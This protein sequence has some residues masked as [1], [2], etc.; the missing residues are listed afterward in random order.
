MSSAQLIQSQTAAPGQTVSVWKEVAES[1]YGLGWVYRKVWQSMPTGST[2]AWLSWAHHEHFVLTLLAHGEVRHAVQVAGLQVHSERVEVVT[3]DAGPDF[4]RDWLQQINTP[5]LLLRQADALKLAR[6]FL[7]ALQSIHALGVVHGDV[8]ADNVCIHPLPSRTGGPVCLDLG[9]LRLIDFAY[10]VYRERP[11]KFVLPTDPDRL[12]Y[13]P[14]FYRDAIRQAQVQNDPALIQRRACAQVDLFSLCCLLREVVP[15]NSGADGVVWQRFLQ[16]CTE[17][18]TR[19]VSD[20]ALEAPTVRLLALTETLLTQLHEPR[21]QWEQAV[22]TLLAWSPQASAT[23]LLEAQ[24]TPLLTPL[25][26]DPSHPLGTLTMSPDEA[27]RGQSDSMVLMAESPSGWHGRLTPVLSLLVLAAVFA[28]I[29]MRFQQTGE[30]LSD[31][32]FGLGLL[33]MVLG[34]LLVVTSAWNVWTSSRRAWRWARPLALG[35]CVIASYFLIVLSP[36]GVSGITLGLL[37]F[38][39][40]VL[41]L[42]W[43][44]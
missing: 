40:A 8:K 32:G 34:P 39:L 9:S 4:R 30:V 37:L 42:V 35:L 13:L 22:T 18:C 16:A 41:A 33:A 20:T 2:K 10:A 25:L 38:L 17:A 1:G 12:D 29:D 24:V 21:A 31:L 6:A 26:A 5:D 7:R 15:E 3:H 11:L 28:F 23:P 43:L 19:S 14:D 27:S 44:A 36:Q